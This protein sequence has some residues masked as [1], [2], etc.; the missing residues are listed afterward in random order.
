M[1][2]DPEFLLLTSI[3]SLS[4]RQA[5]ISQRDLSRSIGLSLGMTNMLLKRLSQKGLVL[6]QKASTRTV[7]Y[8]LTPDGINELARRTFRYLKGTMNTVVGYKELIMN[9]TGDA[10]LRG[11][12]M[13]GLL[14][15]SD[16]DFIIEYAAH[17]WGLTFNRYQNATDVSA[18]TFVF[19]AESWAGSLPALAHSTHLMTLLCGDHQC[20][21]IS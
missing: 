1:E 8:V 2:K 19:V 20:L 9:L 12:R 16:I 5:D 6:M 17:H 4:R 11:Y 3:D 10:K 18:D 7:R 15:T 14:G 21:P 13:V